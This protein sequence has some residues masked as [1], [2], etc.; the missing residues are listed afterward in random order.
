MI[1][2]K[3]IFSAFLGGYVSDLKSAL[4][5]DIALLLVYTCV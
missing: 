4:K 5:A 3:E 1:K 2:K